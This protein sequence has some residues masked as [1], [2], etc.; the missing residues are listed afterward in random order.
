MQARLH[1]SLFRLYYAIMAL[2]TYGV[3]VPPPRPY[4]PSALAW[5]IYIMLC[6]QH[7]RSYGFRGEQS[8]LGRRNHERRDI[9]RSGRG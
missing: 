2:T 1:I 7:G 4:L 9:K 6:Q 5:R 3:C 8:T